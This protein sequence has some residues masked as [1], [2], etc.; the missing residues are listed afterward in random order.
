MNQ[1]NGEINIFNNDYNNNNQNED[2]QKMCNNER[3]EMKLSLRKKKLNEIILDKRKSEIKKMENENFNYSKLIFLNDSIT[4]LISKIEIKSKEEQQIIDLLSM[5]SNILEQKHKN[6]KEQI[7]SNIYNF[8]GEDLVNANLLEKLSNLA[9]IYFNSPKVIL[10]ISRI[11]LFSCLII[12]ADVPNNDDNLLFDENEN[13]NNSGYFISSDKYIDIYNKILQIYL[14]KNLDITNNMIIFIGSIADDQETNQKSMFLSG[15]FKYILDS[16]NIKNDSKSL[17]NKKIFCLSKFSN[18][19]IYENNLKLSL[20]IQEIYIEIF[21]NQEKFELFRDINENEYND[22]NFFFNFMKLIENTSCCTEKIYV[23]NLIKSTIL[24]FLMD[25]SFN[26]YPNI[27]QTILC[28]LID[29]TSV[30]S[31]LGKRLIN[32]GVVKYLKNI[33][34]DKT[35]PSELRR[36]SFISINNFVYEEDLWKMVLFDQKVIE[37]IN[38]LLKEPDIKSSILIEI[39]Y[40]LNQMLYYYKKDKAED[41]LNN[42]LEQ[43]SFIQ[44]ICKAMKQIIKTRENDKMMNL[45]IEQ[46]CSF[47][48]YLLTNYNDNNLIEKVTTKF[49]NSGGEEILDFILHIYINIDYE[50]ITYEDKNIINNNLTNI[51]TIKDTIKDL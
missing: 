48:I 43:Y 23:E 21:L 6:Y 18:S 38:T 50:N 25:N 5:I 29:I 7:I 27:I 19:L 10:Y 11:L 36:S 35:F 37:M 39:F 8:T 20:K 15:T 3:C 42:L 31:T 16:V 34:N 40:G 13:F 1:K 32:I 26:K 49:Q 22:C 33:I 46:F 2:M 14:D 4:N 44:L 9:Q 47:I 51:N 12:K 28:I 41:K 45:C 30:D 24:E 17:L